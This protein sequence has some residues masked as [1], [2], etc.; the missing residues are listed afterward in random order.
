MEQQTKNLLNQLITSF[1]TE[2]HPY[3][4]EFDYCENCEC[5][6]GVIS[7]RD[8]ESEYYIGVEDLS[9]YME[10]EGLYKMITGES[11][12][13]ISLVMNGYEAEDGNIFIDQFFDELE[14]IEDYE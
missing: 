4:F 3:E 11:L 13:H 5:F 14:K 1:H 9:D 12:L 8:N 2:I 10:M 6:Y 7:N